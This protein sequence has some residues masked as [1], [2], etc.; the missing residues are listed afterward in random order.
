MAKSKNVARKPSGEPTIRL[1]SMDLPASVLADVYARHPE[2]IGPAI[3]A[4]P[5]DEND[6]EMACLWVREFAV[7]F[8]GYFWPTFKDL[9]MR[10]GLLEFEPEQGWPKVLYEKKPPPPPPSWPPV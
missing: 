5:C 2:V 10:V 9:E 3:F 4:K 1:P 8:N 7:W 6:A